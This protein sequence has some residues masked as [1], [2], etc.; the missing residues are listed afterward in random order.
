MDLPVASL[1]PVWATLILSILVLIA[2]TVLSALALCCSKNPETS[3][4]IFAVVGVLFGLL[5]AGG[6]GTLFA[7][8]S[9]ESAE[10]AAK[11]AGTAAAT[12]VVEETSEPGAENKP[13]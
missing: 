11:N 7:N 9:V 8:K 5:A 3:K 13:K 10:N 12:Q 1:D 6:L 4:Q 2:G